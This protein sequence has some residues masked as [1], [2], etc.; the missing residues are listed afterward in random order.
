M[1]G[2][3]IIDIVMIVA[4]FSAMIFIGYRAMKRVHNQE[5]YFLAGRRFGRFIQTFA[6]FGQGT[7]AESAVT[8]T[9]M[10]AT[11][12]AGGIG[13]MLSTGLLG[14][15]VFWMTTMWY[16]RL[17]LLTLA[18]YFTERYQSKAMGGFYAF[19]QAIFF[20]IVAA[21]GF[22]AL[23][24]TI[25]AITIKPD[26]VLSQS[27]LAE[28]QKAIEL[29]KLESQDFNLLSPAE[30]LRMEQLR[31]ENPHMI[32]SYINKNLLMVGIGFI[33]LLYAVSGG[34][35]AAFITD[36][37]Q[38]IFIIILTIILIPFAMVRIN[39]IYGTHGLMGPFEALHQHLPSSF[40]DILGSPKLAEFTW[41]WII[42]F[43]IMGVLNTA[44]QAN[45]LTAAGSAKDDE[46]ARVGFLRG[47]FIKRYCTVIWG[48]VAMMTLLLYGNKVDDPDLIWGQATRDLLGGA[49]I[50]L[51]GLMIACLMA[52]LMSTA[53][54][55]MLTTSA[56]LTHSIYRPLVPG[57]SESHYVKAGRIFCLVY[58]V[59][60]ITIAIYNNNVF[61][62]F[63]IMLKFNCI[64]AAAFWLGM[65]WRRAN[66]VAAWS[67][68]LITFLL[69]LLLPL[70][71]PNIPGLHVRQSPYLTKTTKPYVI[72]NIY[73]AKQADINQRREEIKT[74]ERLHAMGKTNTPRPQMLQ[75]GQK[76]TREYQMPAKSIFW[77][78]GIKYDKHGHKY[79]KGMLKVELVVLDWLGW[80]LSKNSYSFNETLTAIIRVVIPFGLLIFIA[81]FSKPQ[82]KI[83]LDRFFGK[84]RTPVNADHKKD[85]Q[86]MVLTL[87][88]PNRFDHLKLFPNSNWEF[89]KWT[90]KDW[91]GQAWIILGIMGV[92]GLMYMI[93]SLGS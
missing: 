47:I 29:S 10:V 84:M 80:D 83:V 56:L 35:E 77:Q 59:G 86:E 26:K 7:S 12:G 43:S 78:Q 30:K 44:V 45:Q 64:V 4:Y 76:F 5:D 54:A 41:Y 70:I 52:A 14:M 8:S 33:V 25:A 1:F 92:V 51:V 58:I 87:Q 67:S 79:G 39:H 62:L 32:F 9:T 65:L 75:L 72:S 20:V 13:A 50:G 22:S 28:K 27:Q 82:E 63:K 74:W 88:N 49:G 66:P 69:T 19:C 71:I 11:N 85:R 46:T 40:F 16:R 89:R 38:G 93:V 34:L 61:G 42:A 17:R 3:S 57:R 36:M 90:R 73:I 60:G 37:I 6:A 31:K 68:M 53:D 23:S 48:L 18:D 81:L 91:T 24:K 15:P 21:L 2:L 55:L